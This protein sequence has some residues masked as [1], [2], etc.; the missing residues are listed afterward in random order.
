MSVKNFDFKK[1]LPFENNIIIK[2]N[3]KVKNYKIIIFTKKILKK[4]FFIF[5]KD[6]N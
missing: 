1:Y 6:N 4:S 3:F 2:F 5:K